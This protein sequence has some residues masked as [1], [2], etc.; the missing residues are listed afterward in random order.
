[1]NL[2]YAALMLHE[3]DKDINE[4]NLQAML[5]AVDIEVDGSQVKALTSALADVDIEE[6]ME[7]SV[8][9]SASAPAE[10]ASGGEKEEK[11]EEAAEE[12]EEKSKEQEEEE[13]AEGLNSLF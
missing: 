9:V 3:A 8:S 11:E 4:D 13:A 7:E 12:E 5:D 2:I 6:A 1:M 10:T